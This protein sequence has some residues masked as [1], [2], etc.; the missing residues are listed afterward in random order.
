MHDH[1]ISST[2]PGPQDILAPKVEN[3]MQ[4]ARRDGIKILIVRVLAAG[5]TYITQIALARA[6]GKSEYGIFATVW[7]WMIIFG[8]SSLLGVGISSSR[9]IPTYLI[10]KR[11]DLLRGFITSGALLV[12]SVAL[13]CAAMASLCAYL[14]RGFWD[15]SLL[16]PFCIAMCVVPFFALQDFAEGVAR[17]LKWPLLAIVPPYIVRQGLIVM[18]TLSALT[19]GAPAFAHT[20]LVVAL[21][22]TLITLILQIFLLRRALASLVP[23][24][25]RQYAFITWL[26][27]SLPMGMAELTNVLLSFID[28]LMLS[29]FVSPGE[30]AIYF[31]ATRLVQ[32]ISFIPF[33][34][35]AAMSP[36]FTEAHARN[37]IQALGHFVTQTARLTSLAMGLTAIGLMGMAPWLLLLFGSGFDQGQMV[38]III[39]VGLICHSLTGPGEDVL[40]ML[41]AENVCAKGSLAM[42]VIA[43]VL[44]SILIPVYGVYGAAVATALTVFMKGAFFAALAK[45][46]VNIWTPVFPKIRKKHAI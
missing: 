6:L 18:G 12:V 42:L 34:T 21:L 7:V 36:R 1:T 11:F 38:V 23:M 37:D 14:L 35:S 28:V 20:A 22:A 16:I 10:Q 13:V 3:V 25:K 29:F 40:N 27:A 44:N 19:L 41:G 8:H 43:F 4:Q 46:Y 26:K 39:G 24:V 2:P 30:V 33:A 45:S 32:L 5:L 15:E 17:S 31:A 9:F